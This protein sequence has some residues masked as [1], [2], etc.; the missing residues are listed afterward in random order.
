M[1]SSGVEA[2]FVS[3]FVLDTSGRVEYP[4][5]TFAPDV[6]RSFRV[7]VCSY[8]FRMRF[9]PVIRDGAPRRALVIT[10]WTFALERGQWEKRQYDVG[11][12]RRAVAAEGLP[13]AVTQL[14]AQPHC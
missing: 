4:T 7:A 9:T 5:I 10:P 8:L 11:P 12:L 14:E 2:G 3:L 13:S 1:R 6:A